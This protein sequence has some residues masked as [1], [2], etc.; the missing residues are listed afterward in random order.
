MDT[1]ELVFANDDITQSCTVFKNKDCAIAASV[2]IS[3]A[4]PSTIK[5]LVAH[6][7]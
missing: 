3:V 1:L 7:L 5:L 4:W 6:I 2:G